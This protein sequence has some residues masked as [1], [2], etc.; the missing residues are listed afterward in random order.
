[1]SDARDRDKT[2]LIVLIGEFMAA[3]REGDQAGIRE[4]TQELQRFSETTGFPNL[5]LKATAT[6]AAAAHQD[7]QVGL[8]QLADIADDLSPLRQ[9]FQTA[10]DLADEGGGSLFFLRASSTLV[11]VDGLLGSVLDAVNNFEEEILAAREDFD[12]EKLR[13][14]IDKISTTGRELSA[15]F[16][17]IAA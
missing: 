2:R 6:I 10:A 8:K 11:Q 14:L 4:A 13:L 16:R 9:M 12:L 7:I 15:R 5:A 17:D 1:M 3:K